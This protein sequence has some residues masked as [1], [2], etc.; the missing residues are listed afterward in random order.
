MFVC[1]CVCVC[2]CV[3]VCIY[4]LAALNE[5]DR[6]LLSGVRFLVLDEINH[7]SQRACLVVEYLSLVV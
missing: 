5:D 1:V 2:M 7:L 4:I 3:Y 6:T